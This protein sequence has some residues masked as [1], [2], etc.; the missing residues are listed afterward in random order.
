MHVCMLQVFMS[1][2]FTYTTDTENAEVLNFFASIFTRSA[3]A[4][5]P[6]P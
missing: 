1:V 3:L 2:H 4:T 5:Q 6:K